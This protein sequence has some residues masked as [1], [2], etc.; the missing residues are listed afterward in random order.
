MARMS[1]QPI[2]G[3]FSGSVRPDWTPLLLL[4][5][6]DIAVAEQFMWM[7]E[8]ELENAMPLQAY[9]HWET[10]RYLHLGPQAEA[11]VFL[12]PKRYRRVCGRCLLD[13]ALMSPRSRGHA[14]PGAAEPGDAPC[15][16]NEGASETAHVAGLRPDARE[17]P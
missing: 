6:H 14:A 3:D 8:I 12:A 5:D 17:S 1:Y 9:K 2:V 10:R 15:G 4:A 13:L 7:F 11:F 16:W